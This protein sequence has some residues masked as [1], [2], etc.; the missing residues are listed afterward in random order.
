MQNFRNIE[1][2]APLDYALFT[3][4]P[5]LKN[6]TYKSLSNILSDQEQGVRTSIEASLRTQL[7]K[8]IDEHVQK[9]QYQTFYEKLEAR[10]KRIQEQL[11]KDIHNEMQQVNVQ[12]EKS[13]MEKISLETLFARER[14]MDV[15]ELLKPLEKEFHRTNNEIESIRILEDANARTLENA[16]QVQEEHTKMIHKIHTTIDSLDLL[17]EQLLSALDIL[18]RTLTIS[19]LDDI[20]KP[21]TDA[22][23]QH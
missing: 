12:V 14:W 1:S 3:K 21:D 13:A 17:R 11:K 15:M 6:I 23:S 19:V 18:K 16:L 2:T 5:T 7:L 20:P 22:S 9:Q 4:E 8:L 10:N